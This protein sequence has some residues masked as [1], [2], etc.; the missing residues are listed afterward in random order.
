MAGQSK[1]LEKHRAFF[2]QL[3]AYSGPTGTKGIMAGPQKSIQDGWIDTLSA[4]IEYFQSLMESTISTAQTVQ[5][6]LYGLNIV[7]FIVGVILIGAGAYKGF[8]NP[9]Q[10]AFAAFLTGAG[11]TGTVASFCIGSMQ[12]IQ[13]SVSDL[14]NLELVMN[15]YYQQVCLWTAQVVVD[16]GSFKDASTALETITKEMSEVLEKYVQ[17]TK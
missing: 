3:K 4:D 11:F 2:E 10:A 1:G 7:M 8:V 14:A 5:H 9:D 12:R 16:S 17:E 13:K 15:N 6:T